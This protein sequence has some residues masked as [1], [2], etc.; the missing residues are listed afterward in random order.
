MNPIISARQE[1]ATIELCDSRSS[2]ETIERLKSMS[3]IS[4]INVVYGYKHHVRDVDTSKVVNSLANFFDTRRN[5]KRLICNVDANA[6]VRLLEALLENQ[7]PPGNLESL[8][9]DQ[10]LSGKM[11]VLGRYLETNRNLKRLKVEGFFGPAA[12]QLLSAIACSSI[13][14]LEIGALFA[15]ATLA[16]LGR[17]LG[18]SS[19]ISHLRVIF[20]NCACGQACDIESFFEGLS[21][22][23]CLE[24]IELRLNSNRSV[25]RDGF[26]EMVKTSRTI[27][28]ATLKGGPSSR[29]VQSFGDGV[30]SFCILNRVFGT[31]LIGFEPTELWMRVLTKIRD[32]SARATF[33]F[34]LLREKPALLLLQRPD[35]D[36]RRY[37]KWHCCCLFK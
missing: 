7:S 20:V 18:Q 32:D 16:E 13:L 10:L 2:I 14:Q 6:T 12:E 3:N 27:T 34:R 25:W 5:I 8:Q 1:S 35:A 22:M 19:S 15:Y 24:H 11:S 9:F 17:K 29:E 37:N 33:L 28:K 26:L 31:N 23:R 30:T 4:T 36:L 21:N